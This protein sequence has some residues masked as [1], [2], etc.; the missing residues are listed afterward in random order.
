M[1]KI[2]LLLVIT[3]IISCK[4]EPNNTDRFR[5]GTF[6]IL[7]EK[8][9]EKTTIIR[10]DSIQIETYQNKTDTLFIKWKDDFNYLLLM[11]NPKTAIDED[12]IFVKITSIKNNSYEFESVIGNSN[13]IEKE[14]IIKI[15][16]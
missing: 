3:S 6:E 16:K 15:S 10:K 12:T 5:I 9:F 2:L 4:K 8:G 7:A 1:K 13:Y 14:K 11:K